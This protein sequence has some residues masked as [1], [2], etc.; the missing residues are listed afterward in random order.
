MGVTFKYAGFNSLISSTL[1]S[2]CAE[3]SS[4]LMNLAVST[5]SYC[6]DASN[7]DKSIEYVDGSS[8]MLARARILAMW[9]RVSLGILISQI[10]SFVGSNPARLAR[11]ISLFSPML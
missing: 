4:K 10:L 2:T 6:T 7:S 9:F 8:K 3:I 1:R 5:F 11:A